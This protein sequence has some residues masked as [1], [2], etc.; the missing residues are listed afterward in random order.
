MKDLLD[1]LPIHNFPSFQL[2]S[3]VNKELE[4]AGVSSAEA[5]DKSYWIQRVGEVKSFTFYQGS[6]VN[7]ITCNKKQLNFN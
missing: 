6:M 1:L 3:A 7:P 2:G 5:L 4:K